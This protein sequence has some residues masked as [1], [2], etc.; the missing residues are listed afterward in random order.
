MALTSDDKVLSISSKNGDSKVEIPLQGDPSNVQFNE[1]RDHGVGYYQLSGQSE[2]RAKQLNEL[3]ELRKKTI[4]QIK[5]K[6]K[7]K[8]KK[9]IAIDQR[10]A[11]IAARRGIQFKPEPNETQINQN[12]DHD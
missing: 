5:V 4:Q 3:N 12:T 1:I 11:R 6:A 10:L 2:E 8:E 7:E 9:S